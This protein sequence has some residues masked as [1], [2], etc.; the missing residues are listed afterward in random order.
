MLTLP[1]QIL[2]L[3]FRG[4][5]AVAILGGAAYL[6][7]RWYDESRVSDPAPAVASAETAPAPA[8]APDRP[9]VAPGDARPTDQPGTAAAGAPRL[10]QFRFD[11]GWNKPTALLASGLTL[12]AWGTLGRL[13]ARGVV[14]LIK[15]RPKQVA[16][17]GTDSPRAERTGEVHWVDR[18]DGSRLRVECYGPADAPPIV[19]THGWGGNSIAFFYP[20]HSLTDRFR[21]IVWD[22]PGLG[23]SKKPDNNDYRLEKMAEDLKAVLAFAGRPAI[24]LGHSIGGMIVLTF[25]RLYGA[26]LRDHAAGLVLVHTT[27]KDPVRTTKGATIYTLL[28]KPVLVPMMYV[29]IGLYPIFWALTW[30]SYWNGSLH[31]STAKSSFAGTETKDQLDFCTSWTPRARPDIVARGML[32]M[33]AYDATA[34]LP[35]IDVPTLTVVGDKDTTTPPEAGQYIAVH[36]PDAELATLAPARHMGLIE[37]HR[38]FDP[39][40]ARFADR[41]FLPRTEARIVAP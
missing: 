36:V 35:T 32:G 8:A 24:L 1:F 37:Q 22:E 4:L 31:R 26:T 17:G 13:I 18:P 39:L 23:L 20:K 9:G 34:T 14:G 6:L 41:C 40:V 7:A 10:R 38:T 3:W 16:G 2:G 28:E 21:V 25:C 29:T 12:L 11:P 30:L 15:P 33:M 27:Y 5:L 19:M